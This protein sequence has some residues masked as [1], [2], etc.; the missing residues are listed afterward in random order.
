MPTVTITKDSGEKAEVKSYGVYGLFAVTKR[1]GYEEEK[2]TKPYVVTHLPTGQHL[3]KS[4]GLNDARFLAKGFNQKADP[5]KADTEDPKQAAEYLYPI[6]KEL[7]ELDKPN[8]K[9]KPKAK[10][11]GR[12]A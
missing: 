11:P 8:P 9:L 12:R 2:Y 7:M 6:Y 3:G 4:M 1:P 5:E 10:P